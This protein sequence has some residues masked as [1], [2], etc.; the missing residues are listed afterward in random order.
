[1]TKQDDGRDGEQTLGV[2]GL[3]AG[4]S[5]ALVSAILWFGVFWNLC[6]ELSSSGTHAKRLLP[7]G[8]LSL[9]V[10]IS[11]FV[12]CSF[13]TPAYD[14][15]LVCL[16]LLHPGYQP[17]PF[18]LPVGEGLNHGGA[19]GVSVG[20]KLGPCSGALQLGLAFRSSVLDL[21]FS[22]LLALRVM[23]L[24]L[25]GRLSGCVVGGGQH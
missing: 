19:P 3:S 17:P 4:G 5:A 16:V 22:S 18:F 12:V 20:R 15:S 9:I 10:L 7:L 2:D 1:M 23:L 24:G 25:C 11:F 6:W 21:S 14:A 8:L 13:Q